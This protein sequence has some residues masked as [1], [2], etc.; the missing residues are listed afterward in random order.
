VVDQP[1]I[2]LLGFGRERPLSLKSRD[3]LCAEVSVHP[4][5]GLQ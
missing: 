5:P 2:P 4:R 3:W 1:P